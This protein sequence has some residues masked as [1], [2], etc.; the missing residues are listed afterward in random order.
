MHAYPAQLADFVLDHWP[1]AV[2][3]TLDRRALA[4]LLSTCFQA[5]LAHEEGR[6][7][8]FRL[9]SSTPEELAQA[10]EGSDF[11]CLE[12][13]ELQD[14]TPDAAR[15]LSPAAPFHS[16]LVGVSQQGDKWLMWG[17][18]HT[19]ANWLAPTWGGRRR[20]GESL[21]LPAVHVLGPGRIGVY[22]GADLVA[23]LEHG[24]IEATTT[25]VFTSEWLSQLF[26]GQRAKIA[27]IQ[28]QAAGTRPNPDLVRVVSQH[29]VRRAIF[30]IRQAGHGGLMLFADTE[31]LDMCQAT[32]KGPLKIKYAFRES[33]AR[34]RYGSL[35]QR[36]F[37]ALAKHGDG[38]VDL[39]RFLAAETKDVIGVEHSIFELSRLVSG[40]AAVDGAV[41][42]NKRF[43]LIGFGAEVSGEL[44]YP[45]V[46]E[47]ALDVEGERRSAEPANSV[48]TR[49]RAAYRFVTA[50]PTGLAIVISMDGIVRFVA[51]IQGKIVYWDQFLNW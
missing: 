43:E 48:G 4:E 31:L 20:G 40:L 49:H 46:V 36:L 34:R 35:L 12:F 47:Q 45:D 37:E 24:M 21:V 42:L 19:G 27:E 38:A 25:D 16:S 26:R 22:S 13:S 15:R 9:V 7:V 10:S 30:L 29:M 39:Q 6:N 18:V 1:V 8:R 5:S 51:S 3:L 17:I 33:E 2:P 23:S 50:H 11:L 14:F 28:A 32:G 44:P 41:V